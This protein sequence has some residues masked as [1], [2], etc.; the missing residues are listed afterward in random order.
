MSVMKHL[1]KLKK[2]LIYYNLK[3][4]HLVSGYRSP[5]QFKEENS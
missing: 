4:V 5:A 2:S 3:R 1:N